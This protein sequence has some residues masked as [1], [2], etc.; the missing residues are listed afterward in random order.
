MNQENKNSTNSILTKTPWDQEA[1]NNFEKILEQIPAPIRGIAESR[2]SKK[3]ESLVIEGSR[4]EITEK[5]IVDAFFAETPGGFL[6]L[7]KSSMKE[8][9]IDYT[10]HGHV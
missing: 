10:K 5:D 9:N 7:M 3:A 4:A 1:L 6:G 8:L 2:V